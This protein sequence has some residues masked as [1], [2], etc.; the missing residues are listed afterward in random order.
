[1]LRH[2]DNLTEGA[3]NADQVLLSPEVLK[4]KALWWGMAMLEGDRELLW[5]IQ[6]SKEYNEE[7]VEVVEKL[8][9]GAPRP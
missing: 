9:M 5:L 1:M 4:V 6:N 2:T 8:Q 3:N 7:L